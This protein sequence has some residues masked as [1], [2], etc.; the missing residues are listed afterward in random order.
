MSQSNHSAAG[1]RYGEPTRRI[2]ASYVNYAEAEAAVDYLA[3]RDF[4][5]ERIAIVGRDVK[6]VEQVTGRVT[7]ATAAAQGAAAGALPG[8]LIGW[9]FGLFDWVDPLTSGLLLAL[10]GLLFGAVV[11]GLLNVAMHAVQGGHRDFTTILG[12]QP[13]RFD[14]LVDAEVAD[15]AV[16]ELETRGGGG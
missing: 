16:R 12:M 6:L 13:S 1:L 2:V 3:D 9:M 5:V 15:Q 4:P 7:Y 14:I 10:Y 8:A 11:G